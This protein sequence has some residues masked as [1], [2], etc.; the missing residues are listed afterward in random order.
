MLFKYAALT[1][2]LLMTFVEKQAYAEESKDY[3]FDDKLLFG[4]VD[5]IDIS[6]IINSNLVDGKYIVDIYFNNKL[7][8][9]MHEVWLSSQD[10]GT[11]RVCIDRKLWERSP[12]SIDNKKITEMQIEQGSGDCILASSV[13][14]EI[15]SD[16]SFNAM[17]LDL[18]L[19][20]IYLKKVNSFSDYENW[21]YG[22]SLLFTNYDANYF[23]VRDRVNSINDRNDN[24]SVDESRYSASMRLRSGLNLGKIQIR[25][26]SSIDADNTNGSQK[27]DIKSYQTYGKLALPF[28]SSNFYF[29]ERY[30]QNRNLNSFMFK[31]IQL[32]SDRR[33]EPRSQQGYAPVITGIAN[34]QSKVTVK[35]ADI[36]IY[37]T[38][39]P[40]GAFEI[41]DIMGNLSNQDFRVE[42]EEANGKK[43]YFIVPN[44]STSQSLRKNQSLFSTS[45]G[46]ASDL[47]SQPLFID[48]TYETGLSNWL[49]LNSGIRLADKYDYFALSAGGVLATQIGALGLSTTHS[50]ATIDENELTGWKLGVDY[51][52]YF[53]TGT[54]LSLANY[55]YSTK[56]F[57][58]LTAL[59]ELSSNSEYTNN[60]KSSLS[61]NVN[62]RFGSQ[63]NLFISASISNYRSDRD[64]DKQVQFGY[65]SMFGDI[66][67][68]LSYLKRYSSSRGIL[69][70][71]QFGNLDEEQLLLSFS[72]P[73]DLDSN[74]YRVNTDVSSNMNNDNSYSVG[75]SNS[76][77]SVNDIQ[78]NA[79]ARIQDV[80]GRDTDRFVSANFSKLMDK[81]HLSGGASR[82]EDYYQWNLGVRGGVVLHQGGLNLSQP[83]GSTF[84]LVDARGAEGAAVGSFNSTIDDNGY[85][86]VSSLSPYT[87]NHISINTNDVPRD[88]EFKASGK[89]VIPVDGAGV[90][91]K[92]EVKNGFP[93]LAEFKSP[94][95]NR[96]PLGTEIVGSQNNRIG[97]ISHG[98]LGYFRVLEP[99]GVLTLVWGNK[100][101]FT[102]SSNYDLPEKSTNELQRIILSCQ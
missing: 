71:D 91:M 47:D 95:G 55:W 62:Q 61:L 39:V 79:Q 32:V 78:Y 66:S 98:G 73:F 67:Y 2:M 10:D 22:D 101:Q 54:N 99:N 4:D 17:R 34:S 38:S 80:S 72:V 41:S 86:V 6:K 75:F 37:Q 57:L 88:I 13:N 53:W 94:D 36:V 15:K 5:S 83:L 58:D 46:V 51:S 12:V 63:S 31:G 65:S 85:G 74:S 49:T 52:K 40:A 25:N 14:S 50:F 18:T 64:P 26:Y 24:N 76:P 87:N 70:V 21:D 7:V 30:T 28:I 82:G 16:F 43:S 11:L 89:S 44:V 56:N 27:Y 23:A 81:M 20:Q 84:A 45:I 35:Q 77:K 42:L 59:D 8:D 3:L 19:A 60:Y 96:I 92:F 100:S 1:V 33:M 9:S 69:T 29:G 102:C 90:L 93:I 68:S 97:F 48:L